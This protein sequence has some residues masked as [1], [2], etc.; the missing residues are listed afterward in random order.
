MNDTENE[1]QALQRSVEMSRLMADV[2]EHHERENKRL[3]KALIACIIVLAMMACCMVYG[4][5]HAQEIVDD[6]LW[7]ALN[8]VGEVTVTETTQSVEGDSATINNVDG[9][10]YN[11]NAQNGGGE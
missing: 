10:Q 3:W 6:A 11:D 8:S 9:E 1:K 5:T 4:I 2:L 7:K